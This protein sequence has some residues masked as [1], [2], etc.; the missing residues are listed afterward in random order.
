MDIQTTTQQQPVSDDNELAKVL[1]GSDDTVA[2]TDTTNT[3]KPPVSGATADASPEV[4]TTPPPITQPTANAASSTLAPPP[5]TA[6]PVQTLATGEL[7]SI[8]KAAL[9]ELRPLAGKLNLPP[10]EKFDTLLLIIRSTDDKELIGS[11]HEAAKAI[12]DETRR[13]QALLD[14]IKEVEYF[15]NGQNQQGQPAPDATPSAI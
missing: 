7:D 3:T 1:G 11:A 8:K 15:S 6:T 12:P 13:A 2:N 9:E 5:I 14:I 10:E 4:T